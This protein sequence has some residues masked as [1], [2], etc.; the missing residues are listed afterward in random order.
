LLSSILS[1]LHEVARKRGG[2]GH[3]VDEAHRLAS[4]EPVELFVFDL[5]MRRFAARILV[6]YGQHPTAEP[7]F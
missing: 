5:D 2:C 1:V 6:N 3:D 7:Y 4:G